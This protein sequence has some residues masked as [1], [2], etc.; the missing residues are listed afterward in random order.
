MSLYQLVIITILE[1]LKTGTISLEEIKNKVVALKNL[2]TTKQD[3]VK[4]SQVKGTRSHIW[5]VP[6]GRFGG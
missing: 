4:L 6:T 5:A 2:A 3:L 1:R